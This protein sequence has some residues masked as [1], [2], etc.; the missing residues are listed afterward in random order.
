MANLTLK[1]IVQKRKRLGRGPGSGHGK[2]STR[3]MSGQKSRSGAR[4]HFFE[5]G[6]TPMKLGLPKSKGFGK[7]SDSTLRVNSKVLNH[8]FGGGE[9]ITLISLFKA[10]KI[11]SSKAKLVR[12]V[13]IYG[14]DKVT[15]KIAAEDSEKFLFS[16]SNAAK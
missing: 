14:S 7:N 16:K 12:N 9:S 15:A 5:G 4:T 10:L 13:K 6:Q 8:Y 1:K 11:P 2:T 3:G